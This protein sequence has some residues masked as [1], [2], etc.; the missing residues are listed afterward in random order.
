ML[1]GYVQLDVGGA[2]IAQSMVGAT[3]ARTSAGLYTVTFDTEAG[4]ATTK[5]WSVLS[6]SVNLWSNTNQAVF[7]Q[8]AQSLSS[9]VHSLTN[10]DSI[11]FKT[12]NASGVPV[13]VGYVSGVSIS[14]VLSNSSVQ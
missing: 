8:V 5:F 12:V 2:I 9:G 11:Q 10:V 14:L 13:D 1:D 7:C 4:G 6:C 3:V